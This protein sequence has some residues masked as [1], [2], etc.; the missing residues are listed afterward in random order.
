M[1]DVMTPTGSSYGGMALLATV[2]MTIRNRAPPNMHAGASLLWSGPTRDL[3]TCGMIRPTK[4]ITPQ[5]ATVPA[6]SRDE[7]I[8]SMM[9]T[10]LTLTPNALALDSPAVMRLSS[11]TLNSTMA[12]PIR[13]G[14]SMILTSPHPHPSKLPSI[15][16]TMALTV[17]SSE[18]NSTVE[19]RPL[20]RALTAM[21]ASRSIV[22]WT[23]PT[24]L[25]ASPYTSSMVIMAMPKAQ[26]TV[27]R[28][29]TTTDVPYAR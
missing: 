27:P 17:S 4:L 20:N 11:R 13:T 5:I 22:V 9:R 15:Q 8:R 23:P 29:L 6:T 18:K 1:I 26:N 28:P 16:K 21:P 14:T 7:P 24:L 25:Y 2:S 10:L 12:I 3:N 19:V